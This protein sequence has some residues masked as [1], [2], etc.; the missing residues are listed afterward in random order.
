MMEMPWLLVMDNAAD[1]VL[2]NKWWPHSGFGAVLITSRDPVFR[3]RNVAGSGV[4][5]REL[6][7]PTALS[8]LRTQINEEYRRPGDEEE[9]QRVV[10][11]VRHLPLGIQ[12]SIGIINKSGESL[13]SFNQRFRDENAL[14]QA[15][16]SSHSF[17]NFAQYEV[18]L[19]EVLIESRRHLSEEER[20]M[21]NIFAL[22]DG[23][24]IQEEELLRPEKFSGAS[25]VRKLAEKRTDCMTTLLSRSIVSLSTK[26][27]DS[28]MRIVN[29]HQLQQASTQ[30]QMDPASRQ[31]AL[32]A[33]ANIINTALTHV[34]DSAG[35]RMAR[36]YK[37]FVP[38]AQAIYK[39]FIQ[40]LDDRHVILEVQIPFIQM[41]HKA[42]S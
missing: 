24:N 4:I 32:N 36:E 15:A 3:T 41:L 19:R 6:D 9:A 12:T 29:I 8:M 2:I 37:E 5:L 11:R 28:D 10:Q 35:V 39:F 42:A 40:Q 23:D 13:R 30:L 27:T 21:T 33:A 14:L 38:H 20:F 18:G 31:H 17:L 34:W 16:S 22:L 1:E 26:A 7:E 25:M